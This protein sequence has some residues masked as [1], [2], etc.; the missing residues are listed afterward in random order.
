MFHIDSAYPRDLIGYGRTPPDPKWP[1]DARIAVQFVINYEEGGENCILHGDAASE[2]FLSEIVGAQ[3]W[4]GMRHMNMESIYEYGS[5]AGFWRLWRLFTSRNLPVTVYGVT[6][7]LARNPEAVA[8]MKEAGWEI[9]SHGLKW[10]DY[11]NHSYEAEKADFD[12]AMELH[13]RLVGERPLGWYTGRTSVNSRRIVMEEGGFLYDSDIYSDDLPFWVEGPSGPHLSIPY[14]LDTN[15]MRFAIPAGFSNGDPFFTYLRDSFDALYA[16]GAEAPKMLSVG[17]HCRLVGRP[18]RI[19]AL[20]RFLDHIA[21][22]DRVWVP[23]RIDI[24]RHWHEHHKP[25]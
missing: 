16:E 9:A 25:E 1:G 13:T 21:R 2:A 4:P 19:L 10:I 22:H 14:T 17:L 3:P 8:A 23:R 6:T 11:R 20:Q 12:A 7:A 5:R 18:G 15:D 24:A